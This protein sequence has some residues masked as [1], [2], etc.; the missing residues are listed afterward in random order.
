MDTSKYNL[1]LI[2]DFDKEI[3]RI[4]QDYAVAGKAIRDFKSKVNILK[5]NDKTYF[6]EKYNNAIEQFSANVDLTKRGQINQLES[7]LTGIVTDPT[8]KTAIQ[9]SQQYAKIDAM[10]AELKT[11]PKYSGMHKAAD[12]FAE[13][14]LKEAYIKSEKLGESFNLSGPIITM[15]TDKLITD[16]VK[17]VDFEEYTTNFGPVNTHEKLKSGNTIASKVFHTLA[18][19]PEAMAAE[20]NDFNYRYSTP[21]AVKQRGQELMGYV[22]DRTTHID[23]RLKKLNA[24]F[25]VNKN[26]PVA[27]TNINREVSELAIEKQTINNLKLDD[28]NSIFQA[29]VHKK[30]LDV[31]QTNKV[32]KQVK[33]ELDQ[34]TQYFDKKAEVAFNQNLSLAKFNREGQQ[35][36][37]DNE[38]RERKLSV[39][40][41]GSVDASGRPVASSGVITVDPTTI[42]PED[43]DIVKD[44]TS[45]EINLKDL[46]NSDGLRLMEIFKYIPDGPVKAKIDDYKKRGLIVDHST[47]GLFSEKEFQNILDIKTAMINSSGQVMTK[48]LREVD[49]ILERIAERNQEYGLIQAMKTKAAKDAGVKDGNTKNYFGYPTDVQ[50]KYESNLKSTSQYQSMTKEVIFSG[51][52]QTEDRKNNYNAENRTKIRLLAEQNGLND[53]S[54]RYAVN[55]TMGGKSG[56]FG[57]KTITREQSDRIDWDNAIVSVTPG[58]NQSVVKLRLSSKDKD[59][60]LNLEG[61]KDGYAYLT[62]DNQT[63]NQLLAQKGLTVENFL[64]GF[65]IYNHMNSMGM[66]KKE[67]NDTLGRG[68]L[69]TRSLTLG[70]TRASYQ[71]EALDNNEYYINMNVAGNK[72]ATRTTI[73]KELL[74]GLEERA[75]IIYRQMK[76]SPNFSNK[77]FNEEM[78]KLVKG[79]INN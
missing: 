4:N 39:E 31:G 11:N 20:R 32:S 65:N 29:H 26:N 73:P 14:Q 62:I 70:D 47:S 37:L 75:L 69:G 78:V 15:N 25:L 17:A 74:K 24:E 50:K 60:T 72:L 43:F 76:S 3:Q 44:I 2:E 55:N 71:V 27:V 5:L 19:N 67:K 1:A 16:T 79:E 28:P 61:F 36:E 77:A 12:E 64:G 33:V 58:R 8:I 13:Q 38:F 10:R 66:S 7:V 45:K 18:S 48:D 49:Q 30:A 68:I 57:N 23:D 54:S 22:K 41:G 42:F 63:A 40:G 46:N 59:K 53:S 51:L 56:S 6:D 21:E 52:N 35:Q 9:S 34:F